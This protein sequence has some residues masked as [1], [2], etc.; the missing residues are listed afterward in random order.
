MNQDLELYVHIPFCV[1]KCS[2]C[3][4]LSGCRTY[5]D[6]SRYI[7]KLLEEIVC[8]SIL[9]DAYTVSSVFIGGGT[10]SVADPVHISDLLFV[11]RRY[12]HVA[13]D[14]EITIEC[15]PGT[16]MR[17]KFARYRE[18]GINRLSIGLQSA[19]SSELRVLGRIHSFEEF[20]KS[21]QAARMEGFANINVD[22]MNCFPTQTAG[23]WKKTLKTV[24]MLRPEHISVY[25]LIVEEETPMAAMLRE[26][27]LAMPSEEEMEAI[28][29]VTE[30]LME[31]QKYVRYEVSN[32][33]KEGFRCRHNLGYWTGVP[34]LGF[35]LGAAGLFGDTRYRNTPDFEQYLET[36]FSVIRRS[37]YAATK[38]EREDL[39]ESEKMREFMILGL[40]LT[41]GIRIRE[42]RERYGKELEEVYGSVTE[43]Y[44]KLQL[45]EREGDMLRFSKRGMDVSNVILAE[46]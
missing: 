28:D 20:L 45:L 33:A 35:G 22:L 5:D 29:A 14:A 16:T 4:F 37:G 6:Q 42:F 2:Y 26:G 38:A 31:S 17:H 30:E 46:F 11:I 13:E 41:E 8:T 36:D 34:Y 3:D 43:K 40:R 7:K 15:N 18:A 23:S 39:T 25:N 24:Q 19:D 12:Y 32:Y 27:K 10:P 44:L 9:A 21:Y 1:R